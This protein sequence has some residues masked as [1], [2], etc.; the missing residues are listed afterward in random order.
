MMCKKKR[1]PILMDSHSA[2]KMKR[3][4]LSQRYRVFTSI[5][6][7]KYGTLLSIPSQSYTLVYLTCTVFAGK[8]DPLIFEEIQHFPMKKMGENIWRQLHGLAS[9]SPF[10]VKVMTSPLTRQVAEP[11]RRSP[12]CE[13]QPTQ[14]PKVLANC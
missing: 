10:P 9:L 7:V 1:F 6:H 13:N 8:M 14:L 4:F 12:G 11:A 5:P 3:R 2:M